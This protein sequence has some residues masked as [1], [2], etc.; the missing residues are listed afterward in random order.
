MSREFESF[1][2][3]VKKSWRS[4]PICHPTTTLLPSFSLGDIVKKI[5]NDV[6]FKKIENLSQ[7]VESNIDIFA[8]NVVYIHFSLEHA[9]L[10]MEV[11]KIDQV[12]IN[13][14]SR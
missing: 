1:T 2:I 14:H 4:P 9:R 8:T 6:T 10:Q 11:E 13:W 5:A 12:N 7:K 3:L